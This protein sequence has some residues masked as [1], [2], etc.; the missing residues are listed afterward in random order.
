MAK[1]LLIVESPAKAKTIEGYLGKDFLVKSSY[2]HIRDL[3]KGDM[4]IDISNN[5]AQTYEVPSDK[6]QVVAEL[7]KLAKDAEMVWLASDE[8]REGEAISWHLYETLGLKENKTK[9]IVFHEITKPAILKAIE[10]P[11]SIDYNLVHAQQARRVL[12][13][14]VG[15]ELSPVLWKKIKPSLSAGRVQSVAV[16][17]IVD[18]EREVNKFNAA[19]AFKI[20]AEFS[21]G[22]GKELVKAELP[23][24]F[25]KEA[26][27]E[28]FLNDC[29]GSGFSVDS[30][31]TKPAKRNPAAPFTTSTLQQE[32][33]RKL[34][35]SV[36]RTMQIAQ[37]LYE[38]GRIT[39][40][41][42]DSVNLSETALQA[43]AAEIK[44]A[45]GDKYHQPRTYKTKSAG[46]Q[47]AHE[48]IRPT[49]FNHHTVP[50]DSSEQRLYELIWK[51]AIASQMSEALF[52]KTTAQIAIS[53]RKE[54]LTAEGEV[55]KFD[56]FLKVYLESSDE[57][58]GED[59]EGNN[60]L[61]PL[62]RGQ[63]LTLRVMNATERFSRPPARY[64]EASLVKKL[65]ELGIG[66]PSTYAP[67]ISTIQNRG[68]VVKEDRDGRQRTFGAIELI[69]GVVTKKTKTEITGAEK[70]KLFPTDI[71]E[72]VNDF[73]VEHFKGIVDFNFTANVEKEFDEIAQ[74]LQEWTKMLHSFYTPFHLEV[75][76]TLETADRANGERLLGV[77]PT[78]GKNVYTKVG[79]FGPLVQIGENDDEEK[80]RYASL[81]KSQSVG[82]VT[83]EEA[84]EQFKLPFQLEDYEGKEVSVGVGRFGPYVKWGE[85]YISIPKN[86]EPL[87]IDQSRAIEI[88]SEKITADAPV[89][90]YQ[91]MPVTKGTGRFGPF[92]KWNDL[93]INVPKA[94]NFD[95]LSQ[96]EIEELIGKKIEKEANRFI[97]QWTAEKIAIENG[98]W[99]PFIRFG[100]EMLK[101]RKN[102]A[103][104]D[105]YTPE[106]L[107]S[108]S[109][110]E[111]KKLIVE[112]VP[113]AFEPKK[114]KA[115]KAT[116]TKTAVKKKAPAKKTVTKK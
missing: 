88:I 77:D 87:S 60:M 1:N 109:L 26:D 111:V 10:T 4:G 89:A 36:S 40:M 18:R 30:L 47:E 57:E 39:Y 7:K 29:V 45:Y 28:K 73:L 42:T 95:Q 44:S 8:D 102:P 46:A 75:E 22:N 25:E 108:I 50:G 79:R 38:S 64:T 3:V 103:T 24:R 86:E 71:G 78:T 106:E 80:P 48:A 113:N 13:R 41:R 34:G 74:G 116:G 69:N 62:S 19:A 43:A 98:R 90:H 70:S 14:L 97:Q 11:R 27:A 96:V 83:L 93:F 63:E 92:I 23:Q 61:P 81:A 37:R 52:E 100:K 53:T 58:D 110:D 115:K 114:A 65:E 94:Y 31:E 12:D 16:R 105:K 5:F 99:G 2:G 32:A 67:T 101:L 20:T 56:G 59:S 84:L 112:Q 76:T 72:V 35:Y 54:Q 21:T 49:Y 9:R 107:A 66:R 82:T 68:Y 6:K 91:G 85:A 15:F 17:L 55:M 33:S 104:N 51:R